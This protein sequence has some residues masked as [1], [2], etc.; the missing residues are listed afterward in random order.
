MSAIFGSFDTS[1][2]SAS[3]IEADCR[4]I[5]SFLDEVDVE[6]LEMSGIKYF[7]SD[8]S[9]D[10]ALSL[11]ET[12]FLDAFAHTAMA[13]TPILHPP[14]CLRLATR[15]VSSAS[16]QPAFDNLCGYSRDSARLNIVFS[17]GGSSVS[18]V[19]GTASGSSSPSWK[20]EGR[21]LDLSD[22]SFSEVVGAKPYKDGSICCLLKYNAAEQKGMK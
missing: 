22:S 12:S 5:V 16:L 17:N 2:P 4:V 20:W 9:F 1:Y 18:N 10:S 3:C 6:C 13:V 8:I 7:G 14:M 11:M 21:C 15:T 19:I